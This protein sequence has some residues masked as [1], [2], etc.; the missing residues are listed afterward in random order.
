MKLT[1]I[2]GAAL[3]GLVVASPTPRYKLLANRTVDTTSVPVDTT[4]TRSDGVTAT[5]AARGF[6]NAIGHN[7]RHQE[8]WCTGSV[9]GTICGKDADNK[10][11]R[12]ANQGTKG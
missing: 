10:L 6:R 11:L 8:C 5:I 9:V 2:V 1:I 4:V 7:P 3:A 12:W